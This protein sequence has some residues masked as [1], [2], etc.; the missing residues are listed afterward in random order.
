MGPKVRSY[1]G[2][3]LV[4]VYQVASQA[5]SSSLKR[6]H[7]RQSNRST[8]RTRRAFCARYRLF[9]RG[10]NRGQVD[11]LRGANLS[12]ANLLAIGLGDAMGVAEDAAAVLAEARSWFAAGFAQ[13]AELQLAGAAVDINH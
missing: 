11:Q 2:L 12:P 6:E 7:R 9:I 8:C 1:S 4:I 13:K 3:I 10:L 5:Q